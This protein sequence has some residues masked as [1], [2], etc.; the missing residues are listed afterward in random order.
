M[1]IT[2][3]RGRRKRQVQLYLDGEAAVKLAEETWEDSGLCVGDE[4][5]D[6]QLREL[7]KES[8]R[9]MAREKALYLLEYRPH[10]K[11]ELEDKISRTLPREAA[12]EAVAKMEE[13]G[14]TDDRSFAMEYAR[15]LVE[16]KGYAPRRAVYELG[17]KGIDRDTAQSAVEGLETDITENILRITDKKYP[18]FAEDEREYNRAVQTL[19]RL[20][21]SF[22]QIRG[23]IGRPHK[24][25]S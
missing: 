3:A 21:Y 2:D 18:R 1:I 13:L 14:L 9:R 10:A 7:L 19:Q 20:G 15:M 22:E 4:I 17:L 25:D 5:D 8:E 23:A 11:K 12:K 16:R 6:E 24:G